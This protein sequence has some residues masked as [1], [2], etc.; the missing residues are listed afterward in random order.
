M[1]QSSC[2]QLTILLALASIFCGC[3]KEE[4]ANK[5][6]KTTRYWDAC[7]PSCAWT[8]NTGSSPNGTAK[9]CSINGAKLSNLSERNACESGGTAY[10]CMD[11]VPWAVNDSLSYGFA[12]SHSNSDCGKCFELTFTNNGEGGTTG[13]NISGKKMII[14]VSNIG[15][16][17]VG[18][19]F[20][21]MIPGGGVGQFNAL[22][23]QISQNGGTPD[24]GSQYGGFRTTCGN[25]ASCVQRMC[26]DAFGS[27]SDL[28]RGCDWYVNWFK[29]ADNPKI[30]YSQIDCPQELIDRYK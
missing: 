11:Q 19:Q 12:A 24:L 1:L 22:S 25:D 5:T 23:N 14:M 6:G 17:V 18:N 10:A 21:L 20:D 30:D 13:G 8:G 16:D 7:K 26:N 27:L 2:K 4:D 15:G 9:S 28:K 3:S 29:I